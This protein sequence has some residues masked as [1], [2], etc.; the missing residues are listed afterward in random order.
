MEKC[1]IRIVG[2]ET[3]IT[4]CRDHWILDIWLRPVRRK[5]DNNPPILMVNR[6]IKS[7]DKELEYKYGERVF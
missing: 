5:W 2:S 6:I 4:V 7:D 3:S 1:L